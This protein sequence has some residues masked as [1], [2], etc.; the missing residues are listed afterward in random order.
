MV[1]GLAQ[2]VMLFA[3]TV[4]DQSATN[5]PRLFFII[6]VIG[7]LLILFA[8]G[9]V[10]KGQ[11]ESF[12]DPAIVRNFN[13][14][15]TSWLAMTTIL[16]AALLFNETTIVVVFFLLS[17]WALREYITMTPTRRAD[18]RTLFWAFVLFTPLQYILVGMGREIEIKMFETTFDAYHLY[19]IMIPVYASLFI[20]FRTALSGDDRRFLERIAKIQFGLLVC[21]YALSYAPALLYMRLNYWNPSTGA[22]E[23]W[24]YSNVGLLFY[25]VVIVQ[26]NDVMQFIWDKMVGRKVIAPTINST[27]TWEG[28]FGAAVCTSLVGMLIPIIFS[29]RITPFQWFG[30]GCMALVISV[31]GF[32]GSITMSAIKRDR[33]VNDYGTLVTGHAG[34]LDRIDSVCFAAPVFY[35]VTRIFLERRMPS[36]IPV[37]SVS[38]LVF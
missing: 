14:R 17:F 18:H 32:A 21:V 29:D 31:M 12:I 6:T 30:S 16:T 34:V 23:P 25:F 33:G 2:S 3:N 10:L 15:I 37:D 1:S 19:S 7:I 4:D 22:L 13:K 36:E 8:I 35:H 20:P 9:R 24:Q 28:F 27:R 11:P 5:Y 26:V 38:Q